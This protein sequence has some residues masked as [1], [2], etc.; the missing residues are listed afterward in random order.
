MQVDSESA[1]ASVTSM[2]LSG[3][4]SAD[5]CI[6]CAHLGCLRQRR[7]RRLRLSIPN[8]SSGE[9]ILRCRSKPAGKGT[10][11]PAAPA[12]GP[13]RR[14]EAMVVRSRRLELPRGLP[15]SALNAARLPIPPRPQ[16]ALPKRDSLPFHRVR[17]SKM[18]G[19][20]QASAVRGGRWLRVDDD[21]ARALD[22]RRRPHRAPG[23]G[24]EANVVWMT[25]DRPVDYLEAVRTME[26]RIE[27]I[28]A[29]HAPETVWLLEHPLPLHRRH[30]RRPGRIAA[31][32]AVSRFSS[33]G[34]GGRYT[35]HG[36]GQ[37]IGYV[38][39]DV[40]ARGGDVRAF[41]D[42]LEGWIIGPSPAS[43][44]RQSDGPAGSASG[45]GGPTAA[46][47]RSPP[48]AF[49]CAVG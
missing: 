12:A 19:L 23:Q 8:K 47:R 45:S 41:V 14:A 26:R 34:R 13:H 6:T 15:H 18:P 32:G 44:S 5:A 10:R 27:A 11:S 38:M 21:P 48:S 28:R 7:R 9:E 31:T 46:T 35:Y 24:Q 29:G 4:R 20:D 16:K 22:R 39:L 49:G 37:R 36:P 42:A 43:A 2:S 1:V 17:N 33:R 3:P 40:K 25:S 30:Q